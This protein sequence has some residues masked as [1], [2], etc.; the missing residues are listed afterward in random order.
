MTEV[1][2]KK[3]KKTKTKTKNNNKIQRK[4]W[5]AGEAESALSQAV[6]PKQEGIQL[7]VAADRGSRKLSSANT[8]AKS[9]AVESAGEDRGRW[10]LSSAWNCKCPTQ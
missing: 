8:N 5:G 4:K 6:T 3:K 9:F 1:I 10:P 2:P 7:K